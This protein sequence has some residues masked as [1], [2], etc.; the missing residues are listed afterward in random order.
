MTYMQ[1]YACRDRWPRYPE[2]IHDYGYSGL[3]RLGARA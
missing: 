2:I 3:L 1:Y